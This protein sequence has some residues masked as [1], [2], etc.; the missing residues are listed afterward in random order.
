MYRA[1]IGRRDVRLHPR[2]NRRPLMR[3]VTAQRIL[4]LVLLLT[5]FVGGC[6]RE[7][8]TVVA[9]PTVVSTNPLGGA[10]AVP[11]NQ[12]LL[13]T[14]SQAMNPATVVLAGTYTVAVAGAGGATVT[15]T[16]VYIPAANSATFSPTANLLPSTQY[17]ATIH[18]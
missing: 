11:I 3:N 9:P 18:T 2:F 16:V 14:F 15:G 7:Q 17:T 13:A 12:K 8:T 4:V 6:G 10:V 1:L 5:G